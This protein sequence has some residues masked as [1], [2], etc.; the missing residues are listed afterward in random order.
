MLPPNDLG[1]IPM[2]TTRTTEAR[3]VQVGTTPSGRGVHWELA[4]D[5]GPLSGIVTGP[6]MSG[7]TTALARVMEGA[8]EVGLAFWHMS[9]DGRAHAGAARGFTDPDAFAAALEVEV[10]TRRSGGRAPVLV[11]VDD[12]IRILCPEAVLEV[13]GAA[14]RT[15]GVGVIARTYTLSNR[16]RPDLGA[17]QH[18]VLGTLGGVEEV[19]AA[20]YVDGYAALAPSGRTRP[21]QGVYSHRG[22]AVP[23]TVTSS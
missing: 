8:L 18:L 3:S 12:L 5:T 20:R 1:G 21:G 9:L 23:L 11:V 7:A 17:C 16:F 22:R 14:S 10:Q 19:L 2:T 4:D 6:Q 15:A 13:L